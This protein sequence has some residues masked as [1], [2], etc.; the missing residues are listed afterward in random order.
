MRISRKGILYIMVALG[1]DF[2]NVLK[3]ERLMNQMACSGAVGRPS[4]KSSQWY[5]SVLMTKNRTGSSGG[6]GGVGG[7]M[8]RQET[9]ICEG[10][11]LTLADTGSR[12][13]KACFGSRM[14]KSAEI[15][16]Q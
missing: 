9:S 7:C 2:V 1:V 4:L 16:A 5:G 15:N 10:S 11:L 6:L 3:L 8:F 14:S 13:E 12:A